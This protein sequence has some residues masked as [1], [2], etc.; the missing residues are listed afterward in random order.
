MNRPQLPGRKAEVIKSMIIYIYAHLSHG[1]GSSGT[2]FIQVGHS[3][4]LL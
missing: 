3:Y 4:D 1:D 2:V